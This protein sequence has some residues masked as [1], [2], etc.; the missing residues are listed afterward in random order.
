MKFQ[1]I[2]SIASQIKHPKFSAEI[3][4]NKMSDKDYLIQD[5]VSNKFHEEAFHGTVKSF[6]T[7]LADVVPDSPIDLKV[8]DL[9]TYTNEAGLSWV[10]HKILGFDITPS[11]KRVV[12]LDF[13]SY[14]FAVEIESLTLQE[15]YVGLNAD[16]MALIEEKYQNSFVPFDVQMIRNKKDAA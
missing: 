16:D 6:T 14:W 4:F 1:S 7:T 12:Y 11:Y 9:V 10:N 3:F 2:E 5:Q 8:G 15:G 13:S